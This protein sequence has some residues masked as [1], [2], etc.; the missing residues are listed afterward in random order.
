M[1]KTSI[2]AGKMVLFSAEIDN[3]NYTK[4]LLFK[5]VLLSVNLS[6]YQ[7]SLRYFISSPF[8]LILVQLFAKFYN[9]SLL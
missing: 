5:K 1:N 8:L 4:T 6:F 9:Y 3:K 2:P 7:G